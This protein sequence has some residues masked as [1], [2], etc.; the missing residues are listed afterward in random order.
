MRAVAGTG[1]RAP[2]ISL[3]IL[4]GAIGL[5]S[6]TVVAG[7]DPMAV[8]LTAALASVLALA[9]REVLSWRSLVSL[10]VLIILFIPMRRYTVPVSLPIELDPYRILV[11]LV[12]IGWTGSLLADPHVRLRKSGLEAPLI[13]IL[14]ASLASIL[15]NGSRVSS[16]G[17][18]VAKGLTFLLS[19][20]VVFFLIASVI[21]R[22]DQVDFLLRVLVG[23][24]AVLAASAIFESR[25]QYNVFDHLSAVIPILHQQETAEGVID[26]RGFRAFGSAQH[27][28]ALSAALVLLLPVSIYLVRRDGRDAGGPRRACCSPGRSQRCRV[29][30]SSCW[31]R[32]R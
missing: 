29:R 4:L 15:I 32:L 8:A 20:F 30:A 2:A 3:A 14:A 12:L 11:A 18:E 9:H 6:L 25:T 1:E 28:I 19:Y 16:V 10:L 22:R 23:G 7:G 13:L 27:P 5:L 31:S 17:I 26:M 24:G 21:R